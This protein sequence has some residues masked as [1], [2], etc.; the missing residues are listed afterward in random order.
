MV[1]SVRLKMAIMIC[2]IIGSDE[3]GTAGPSTMAIRS[4]I[5]T[6]VV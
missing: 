1:A 5:E 4:R 6:T 3:N 2:D